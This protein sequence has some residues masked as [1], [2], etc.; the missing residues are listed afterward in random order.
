M[1]YAAKNCRN[2]K[3]YDKKYCRNNKTKEILRS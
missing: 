3:N 1:V 2:N